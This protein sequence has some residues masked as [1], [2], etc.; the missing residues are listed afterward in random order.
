M[1]IFLLLL[2]VVGFVGW[3]IWK[4]TDFHQREQELADWAKSKNLTFSPRK[5]HLIHTR[6]PTFRCLHQ[7]QGYAYNFIQGNW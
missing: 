5:D 3:W 7:E 2:I 6:F 4:K 1:Q